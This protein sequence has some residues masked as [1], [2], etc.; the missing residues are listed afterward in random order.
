MARRR[1]ETVKVYVTIS[2]GLKYG[3]RTN[4]AIHN[5]YKAELGQTEYNGAAGVVF[6]ANAP[7]PA[8]ASKEFA[9]G[10]IGSFCSTAKIND[11][12]A[13]NWVVTRKNSI[14]GIKT[15]GK[16]RTVFVE[17][18]GG[19]KH[20]WNL[21]ASEVDLAG[22]LGFQIATGADASDLVWGVN[23]PKPPRA[24]KRENGSST[25][26]FCKPQQSVIDAAIEAGFSISGIDYDL[27]PN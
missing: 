24:T 5:S 10:T 21:T 17:M 16:T 22:I 2:G 18:P 19:Y 3:F 23:S 6:G 8:K 20:A 26:T 27:L 14:R 9:S 11:L 12:R 7:K 25:S 4:K 15:G 1:G 13:A